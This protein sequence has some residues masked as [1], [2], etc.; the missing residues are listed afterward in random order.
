M[1]GA[2]FGGKAADTE[3]SHQSVAYLWPCNVP[4]WEHWQAVQS[5]W[6]VGMG[7]ATG[8]DYAG[9]IAYLREYVR[10]AK[11]RRE[12]L[13]GIRAAERATLDVWAAQRAEADRKT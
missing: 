13:D 9:V 11:T 2:L 7:G 3:P 10:N 5:Q 4:A 6:R 8:L 1:L 12:T